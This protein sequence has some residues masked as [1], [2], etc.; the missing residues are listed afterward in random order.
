MR[1]ALD[2]REG[3]QAFAALCQNPQ[4]LLER[5]IASLREEA[6][7]RGE[8]LPMYYRIEPY[9]GPTIIKRPG[10]KRRKARAKAQP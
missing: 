9:N 8:P 6:R 2:P 4:F 7:E 1:A 10:L 3:G 5:A